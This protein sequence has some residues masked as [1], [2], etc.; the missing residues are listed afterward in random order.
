LQRI[1]W[2]GPKETLNKKRGERLQVPG[3][4]FIL[5]RGK[6]KG[7]GIGCRHVSGLLWGL[8]KPFHAEPVFKCDGT[9]KREKEN[10]G[11]KEK[12]SQETGEGVRQLNPKPQRKCP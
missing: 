1:N 11:F 3:N 9:A 8:S 4:T 5:S 2:G 10:A 12:A 6:E 7:V